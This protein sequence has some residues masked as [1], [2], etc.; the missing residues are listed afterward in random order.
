MNYSGQVTYSTELK[1]EIFITTCFNQ[2]VKEWLQR[3]LQFDPNERAKHFPNGAK[4]FEYLQ[5]ILSKKI[6][7]VFALH[8]LEFYSYEI[9]PS[10]L[11][12]TVKDWI[13]RDIKI[14][15]TELIV[16]FRTGF[17]LPDDELLA[18]VVNSDDYVFVIHRDGLIDYPVTYKFPKLIREVMKSALKFHHSYLWQL[19]SQTVY[20]ITM[21]RI[22]ANLFKCGLQYYVSYLKQISE[23]LRKK[24]ISVS[25]KLG[26]LLVRV[27]CCTFIRKSN[28]TDSNLYENKN[29]ED[30]LI[31]SGQLLGTLQ[32]NLNY[33]RDFKT[34]IDKTFKR[35]SILISVWPVIVELV[36]EY[37]LVE[38]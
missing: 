7:K 21:E 19:Y 17:V 13:S 24:Y 18:S 34:K 36:N 10:T 32:E 11:V 6:I 26:N 29:Y 22:R 20:Y 31:N 35:L 23:K 28:V 30:C 12:G 2:Y 25:K 4:T 37:N 9:E 14:P 27:D 16:L 33:Y 8:K 3:T 38:L 1:E 5:Q 15:K